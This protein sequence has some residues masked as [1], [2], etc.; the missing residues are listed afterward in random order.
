MTTRV[1]PA[2]LGP[3]DSAASS[4]YAI[5][6]F[7]AARASRA[8]ASAARR[9][10]CVS[11]LAGFRTTT[12]FGDFVPA[13][14]ERRLRPTAVV[15]VRR[16]LCAAVPVESS[17]RSTLRASVRRPF[18]AL[19]PAVPSALASRR[20]SCRFSFWFSL[21]R[22]ATSVVSSSRLPEATGRLRVRRAT[23][24]GLPLKG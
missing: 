7:L 16:F 21:I 1:G 6:A 10:A 14:P 2:P 22:E 23:G 9:L 24:I 15:D 20:A 13:A 11:R 18:A 12:G 4:R 17:A 19:L 3:G 5:A 8:R